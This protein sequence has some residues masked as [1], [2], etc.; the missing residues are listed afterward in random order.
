VTSLC[1]TVN[2]RIVDRHRVDADPD[3]YLYS[4]ADTDPDWH[5]NF[6][7]SSVSLVHSQK[8]QRCDDF[9]YF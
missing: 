8:W 2:S 1:G 4:D 5:Q 3:V 9:K 6:I 7:H